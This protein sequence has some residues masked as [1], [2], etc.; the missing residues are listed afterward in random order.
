MN[1]KYRKAI[2]AGNW[3]MNK[4]PS[5]SRA[6]VEELKPLL[7]RSKK[8]VS[9][10]HP[11]HAL[12]LHPHCPARQQRRS[13]SRSARRTSPRTTPA[14]SPAKSAPAMLK[15]IG[16]KY[17]IVGHSERRQYHG[18]TDSEVNT[19]VHKLLE[20]GISPII[21]VGESLEQREKE[22]TLDFVA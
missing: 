2:I 22:L 10:G 4:L 14:R 7:P 6:F 5:E 21:C 12:S 3:K 19:K 18:E 8:K 13:A 11:L 15:D 1:K 16:C 9:E 20:A 17:C